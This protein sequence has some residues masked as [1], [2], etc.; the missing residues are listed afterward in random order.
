MKS[1][2]LLSLLAAV[3]AP[4]ALFTLGCSKSTDSTTV[5]DQVKSGAAAAVVDVKVAA[6]DSW[7]SIKDF[8][9]DRRS[10]FSASMDKMADKMD[11]DA[12]AV[13]SKMAGV[14]DAASKDRDAAIKEYDEARADLKVKMTDL[15]NA[16]ADTWSD[17]KAKTAAA[18]TRVRVA[19]D[20]AWSN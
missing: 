3:V 18:W 10:D 13:R 8:T 4:A 11:E 12:R 14:P 1:S 5:V 7:D 19:Y 16:T 17:A 6:S 20:K 15:G 9:Y 2:H